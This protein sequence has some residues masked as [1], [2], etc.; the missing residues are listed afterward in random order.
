M[1]INDARVTGCV[2]SPRVTIQNGASIESS[3]IMSGT[4]IG[5]GAKIRNTIIDKN[6][7]IPA[8]AEIGFDPDSD[9][10]HFTVTDSGLV[11]IPKEMPFEKPA[12]VVT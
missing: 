2:I 11:V 6:V 3:V 10:R 1:V 9:R 12:H 4:T 8:G 7:R 5:A